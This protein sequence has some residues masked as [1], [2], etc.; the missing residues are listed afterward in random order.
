ML[1]TLAQEKKKGFDTSSRKFTDKSHTFKSVEEV[2]RALKD[3]GL[4][5]TEE[6]IRAGIL[7]SGDAA[8]EAYFWFKDFFHFSGDHM[9]NSGEIHIEN[10]R[11]I[12]LYNQYS[13]ECFHKLGYTQWMEIWKH[14]FPH[15]KMR[16]YKQV[17][18][19]NI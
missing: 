10:T 5:E 4:Q 1:E 16:E 15:V 9:P 6:R 3:N 7:N 8:I 18:I 2:K 11:Y 13:R 12:A 14:L 17:F 19:C